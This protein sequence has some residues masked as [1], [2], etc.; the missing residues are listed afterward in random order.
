MMLAVCSG[1]GESIFSTRRGYPLPL[2]TQN[3][4]NKGVS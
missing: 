2:L 3:M 1:I 4:E